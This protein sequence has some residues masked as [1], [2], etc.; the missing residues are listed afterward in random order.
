MIRVDARA[1][2]NDGDLPQRTRKAIVGA[3]KQTRQITIVQKHIVPVLCITLHFC[4]DADNQNRDLRVIAVTLSASFFAQR[5]DGSALLLTSYA[6]AR[7]T[8]RRASVRPTNIPP[9]TPQE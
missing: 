9:N 6:A 8:T 2:W 7:A 4:D 5:K 1:V 3:D